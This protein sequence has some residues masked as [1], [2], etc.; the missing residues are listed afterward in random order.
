MQTQKIGQTIHFYLKNIA[1]SSFLKDS[2]YSNIISPFTRMYLVT[3]GEGYIVFE[4]ERT[5]LEGGY[6]YL[7]PG[8][9]PCTYFFK[10]NLAH[11]Y[12]HFSP[13]M[14]SGLNIYSLF[15]ITRKIAA[16]PLDKILF[17]RCLELN[18]GYELPHHDP[19]VYQN[20]PW[21]NKEIT[22]A[23][24]GKYLETTGIIRQLFSRFTGGESTS[25]I[26]N[27]SNHNIQGILTYIQ[28][29]LANNLSVNELACRACASKDHF[30]RIFK[31][32]TGI[33][34]SEFIIRKRI[35]K[36]KL[37]L[38]TTNCPL[39]EI[40]AQTGFR[41]TGYFCRAF[42]KFTSYT[43]MEFRMKRG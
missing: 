41:T 38:L 31:S 10:K 2:R 21:I 16:Q 33:P 39:N 15:S 22:Y 34:P 30:T 29:N 19:K 9:T 37:L 40:I 13:E 17:Q 11:Y 8:F 18:P 14:P 23:T 42:K 20:K 5:E 35:E 12:I 7:I 26:S 28:E 43:P 27:L 1:F 36:A 24:V 3:E 6:L 25:N 4:G 32:V